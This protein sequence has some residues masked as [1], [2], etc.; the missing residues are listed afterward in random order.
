MMF[1][2]SVSKMPSR[3]SCASFS[4]S[5]LARCL[6]HSSG[7]R[8]TAAGFKS[9]SGR[10]SRVDFSAAPTAAELG[11]LGAA[12]VTL[13]TVTAAPVAAINSRLLIICFPFFALRH[14]FV[15]NALSTF[16]KRAEVQHEEVTAALLVQNGVRNIMASGDTTSDSARSGISL[17]GGERVGLLAVRINSYEWAFAISNCV[18]CGCG[19]AVGIYWVGAGGR[20]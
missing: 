11:T 19:S 4:C 17:F 7:K 2:R 20:E 9:S 1:H 3:E 18:A 5:N 6:C 14:A 15:W 16:S 10:K 12:P 13:V 8:S